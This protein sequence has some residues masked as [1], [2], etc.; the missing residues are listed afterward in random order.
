MRIVAVEKFDYGF[1]TRQP[2]EEF[3]AEEIH[4]KLLIQRGIARAMKAEEPAAPMTTQNTSA[5]VPPMQPPSKRT[6]KRRDMRA[7]D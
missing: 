7:E 6:Y 4:G 1:R 2:G 3:E 5:I